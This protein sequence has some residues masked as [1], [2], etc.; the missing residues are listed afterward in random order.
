[1]AGIVT[2]K[3]T[4]TLTGD[5]RKYVLQFVVTVPSQENKFK[6][7]FSDVIVGRING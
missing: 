5:R 3:G 4:V 6:Y 7:E 1:M 2:G